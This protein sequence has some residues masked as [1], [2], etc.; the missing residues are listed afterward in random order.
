MQNTRVFGSSLIRCIILLHLCLLCKSDCIAVP[1]SLSSLT[2]CQGNTCT[3]TQSTNLAVPASAS[4]QA[5]LQFVAPD[6]SNSVTTLNITVDHANF[7][8]RFSDSR[9]TDDPAVS[10][11]GLCGCPGGTTAR[12]SS[13]TPNPK[14]R[15]VVFCT[16][17]VGSNKGCP[18]S[19]TTVSS[20]YAWKIG[21]DI[22]PRYKILDVAP[23]ITK[24]IGIVAE[25]ETLAWALD[26][27]GNLISTQENPD[28]NITILSDTMDNSLKFDY[29]L[30]DLQS[31]SDWWLLNSNQV[32]GKNE[33]NVNKIGWAV[34][35]ST[36][37]ID[38]NIQSTVRMQITNCLQDSFTYTTTWINTKVALQSYYDRLSRNLMPAA[39]LQD[40]DWDPVQPLEKETPALDVEPY[41]YMVDGWI[42]LSTTGSIVFFG[43]NLGGNQVPASYSGTLW[44][45]LSNRWPGG[46]DVIDYNG[47]SWKTDLNCTNYPEWQYCLNLGQ[48]MV[49]NTG[50]VDDLNTN[51]QI[52]LYTWALTDNSKYGFCFAYANSN[53]LLDPYEN[54]GVLMDCG[55]SKLVL[56]VDFAFTALSW[57]SMMP[58]V[59]STT[60]QSFHEQLETVSSTHQNSVLTVPANNGVVNLQVEFKNFTIQFQQTVI[61]PKINN[62][63]FSDGKFTFS[64]QSQTVAGKC[65]LASD[66]SGVVTGQPIELSVSP[67]DFEIPISSEKYMG[68]VFIVIQ[69]YTY[70][71][72]ASTQVNWNMDYTD[73]DSKT[74][75]Q[76]YANPWN[77][78]S[79]FDS[80][81]HPW[82]YYVIL[83]LEILGIIILAAIAIWVLKLVFSFVRPMLPRLRIPF[84]T[85]RTKYYKAV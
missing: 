16:E 30:F 43:I 67:V 13:F 49:K 54:A 75:I 2:L 55:I 41:E 20:S 1:T 22:N 23:L 69:C 35:N 19:F 40:D 8:Y 34:W 59:F 24:D 10:E 70:Q 11:V 48:M 12:C 26:Y 65:I 42:L 21:F 9:Y 78:G 80:S 53:A 77:W 51:K 58:A 56:Q 45:T 57:P 68:L 7:V 79:T 27:T 66:P 84:R 60:F 46:F 62:L 38:P 31:Q 25:T 50:F 73:F 29:L 32:N 61:R 81:G 5:C 52:T 63:K 3:F 15:D 6:G 17:G 74:S 85:R 44:S 4:G 82:W 18:L 33:R 47:Q 39:I 64:A 37:P 72:K 83:A 76:H 14:Y 28:F 71:A 36:T